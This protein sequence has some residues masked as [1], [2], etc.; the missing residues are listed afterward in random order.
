MEKDTRPAEKAPGATRH[1]LYTL[2]PALT[3]VVLGSIGMVNTALALGD[4]GGISQIVIGTVVLARLTGLP[5]VLA[6]VRLALQG[7][8]SWPFT[9]SSRGVVVAA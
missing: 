3:A 8:G 1:D 4:R 5:N 6:S 7:R 9:W 2:V